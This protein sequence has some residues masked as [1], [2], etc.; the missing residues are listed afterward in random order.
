VIAQGVE[1]AGLE[2][3]IIDPTPR[4]IRRN[5]L[6]AKGQIARGISG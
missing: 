2:V 5:L 1:K 4:E 3:S 6:K